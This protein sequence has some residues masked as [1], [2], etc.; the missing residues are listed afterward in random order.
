[1][2]RQPVS[3]LLTVF[4]FLGCIP[5]SAQDKQQG[6]TNA[7]VV[8]MVQSG[9]SESAIIKSIQAATPS[10]E[11][12]DDA[13]IAMKEQKVSDRII[14]AM[15]RR[16]G[17]APPPQKVQAPSRPA[18]PGVSGPKWEIEFHGGFSWVYPRGG[19]EKPPEAETY[20]LSG[21]GAQGYTSLRVSSWY[22]GDGA[23]LTNSSSSLDSILTRPVVEPDEQM[24][25]F[26]VSRALNKWL[27]AEF[28]F[29]RSGGLA[30]TDGA[31]AQ[32]EAA[33]ADF[34]Q[35][36]K[37]L[38]VPGNSPS[39]SVSTVSASG[40]N[41]IFT[42]AAIVVN[43][44]GSKIIRPYLTAGAGIVFSGNSTPN[45]TLVGSYG[46]PTALE[47]DSVKIN[48]TPIHDQAFAEVF[49]AG[50]KVMLSTHLGVRIDGRAYFHKST[51][52]TLLDVN[53]TNTPDAA[54]VVNADGYNVP[55]LQ[56]LSGPGV[57]DYSTLSGPA[58]SKYK[59]YYGSGFQ[60]LM[61]VSLGL[62]WRF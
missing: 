40:G 42:T 41:Q 46:G 51:Y 23:E 30:I 50:V 26:R 45:V 9:I 59:T 4:L 62:F 3:F 37:R 54:W 27:A 8:K 29:D 17:F 13:I 22:Y 48:F 28:T 24:L 49:G 18:S 12:T 39:T 43:L 19:W 60:R 52:A 33:R 44:P 57:E 20:S 6:M 5:G 1:M 61:P 47:T 25:G 11:I 58:L 16:Q 21:S 56:K 34:Q 10:F 55:Y 31:L 7:D 53:H 38:D 2:I 36:W 15:M 14:L 32:V 35:A